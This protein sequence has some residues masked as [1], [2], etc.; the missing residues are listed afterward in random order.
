M[1]GEMRELITL[2]AEGRVK[3]H[4]GRIAKLSELN[5]VFEELEQGKFVGR[6][7]INDFTK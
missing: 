6:A 1:V 7:I 4:I 2:A 5:D 3:T